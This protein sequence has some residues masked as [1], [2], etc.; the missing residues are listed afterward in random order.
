MAFHRSH[1]VLYIE[2]LPIQD[3]A[4]QYGTPL[5]LYSKQ[6]ILEK[7]AQYDRGLGGCDHVICFPVKCNSNQALLHLLCR[8]GC[9]FDVASSGE[10]L[11]V[12]K[13]HCNPQ[14]IVF[15]GVGKSTNELKMGLEVGIKCFNTESWQE[16]DRLEEIARSSGIV[17]PVA[18]RVNP[19]I[20][21][22][23]HP[24]LA[25]GLKSNKFGIPLEEA[26]ELYSRIRSSPF[27]KAEGVDCHVG[28]QIL[29]LQPLLEARDCLLEL[30]NRVGKSGVDLNFVDLGGGIGVPYRP[31]DPSPDISEWVR[32]LAA[33]I[34]S[35]GMQVIMEPGR[36]LL[37]ESG[38]LVTTIEYLKRG[39]KNF[40]I[41]DASMTELIR[42]ALYGSYHRVEEVIR[43]ESEGQIYD[44]V[45][46]V[47]ENSDVLAE[48][49]LLRVLP[50][51]LLVIYHAGA[52]GSSMSSNFSSRTRAAEVMVDNN[53]SYLIR[54]RESEEELRR[55]DHLLPEVAFK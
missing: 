1:G 47:C 34:F 22:A 21:A 16:I 15:S 38:V 31:N 39:C 52:Y 17:A 43:R 12:L 45:G 23:T 26:P 25:T 2:S 7:L 40:A 24:Y 11:R 29:H 36:S 50:G 37:A 48:E 13:I 46:P 51:D 20:D 30:V 6:I 28:S 53:A 19:D 49:R 10:L 54:E 14:N 41:V 27:L 8:Q 18:V 42:P 9:G 33:P 32:T 35:K 4:K 5:Y 3:L 44:V 55:R